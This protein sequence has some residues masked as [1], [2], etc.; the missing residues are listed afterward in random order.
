MILHYDIARCAGFGN[1]QIVWREGCETCLRR[2]SARNE[3]SSW[4]APPM[5]IVGECEY[6]I[7]P[8]E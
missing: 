6:L 3:W 5:I 1:D 2:T 7:E 4:M 8:K